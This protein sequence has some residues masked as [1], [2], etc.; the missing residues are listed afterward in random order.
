M[1]Q[2][3]ATTPRPLPADLERWP[4]PY[5]WLGDLREAGTV[6]L[7][8]LRGGLNAW[9][10]T[11]YDDVLAALSDP[12]LS[13]D[14]RNAKGLLEAHGAYRRRTGDD[15]ALSMLSS[16]PPDH[17]RLRRLVSRAFTARRVD[18]LRPRV[19]EITNDLLDTIGPRGAADVV[20]DYALPLPVSVICELLGVPAADRDRF[21][22]WSSE[23]LTPPVDESAVNRSLAARQELFGY[24]RKL[25][26]RR[27]VERS[28]DLLSDLLEAGDEGRLSD[29]ELVA[30]GV[31]LLVAGHETTVNLIG[32]GVLLLLRHPE[33]R[34]A[35]RADG[36]LL[37]GA[38]EEFLRFDGPVMLGLMRYAIDDVEIGGVLIPRGQVAVLSTG[39]ANRDPA[40]FDRPDLVDIT[41][42][43]N[44]HVAFGHGIHYCLG[45]ALARLEGEIAIGALIRRF[46]DLALAVPDA[47]LVWR[48]NV[49]RGLDRLPVTFTPPR[50]GLA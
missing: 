33:Q 3:T 26:A 31:L 45:A 5:P 38:V 24:L 48:P 42:R 25:V 23:L 27:S 12:R 41:R 22:H 18:R 19:A 37:P 50:P 1:T 8:R 13:S 40:R 6:Q 2:T 16:D 11:R 34:A 44:G 49:I 7:V 47:E 9:M 29:D 36:T 32:T 20:A 21:R 28:D 14:P 46:P 43:D 15:F 17:T 39:A 35:L 10:V 30:M 4:D